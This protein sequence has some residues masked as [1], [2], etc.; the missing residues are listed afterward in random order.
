MGTLRLFLI[1]VA[2]E[3]V[4]IGVLAIVVLAVIASVILLAAGLIAFLWF[5]KRSMRT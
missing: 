2:P 5:R 1:D 4:G 3:P